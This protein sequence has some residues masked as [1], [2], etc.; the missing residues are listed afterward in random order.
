MHQSGIVPIGDNLAGNN[1]YIANSNM[2]APVALTT[3]FSANRSMPLI[4]IP[5]FGY[6]RYADEGRIVPRPWRQSP[7]YHWY[8]MPPPYVLP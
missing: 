8:E 7:P 6:H 5:S 2:S 3:R 4:L 1:P